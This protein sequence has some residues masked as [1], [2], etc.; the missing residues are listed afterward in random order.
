MSN[1]I[2]NI[3]HLSDLHFGVENYKNPKIPQTAR[4]RR[5]NALDGLIKYLVWLN[6]KYKLNVIVVTGDIGWAG[7]KDDY[8]EAKKWF[9]ELL[10]NLEFSPEQLCFVPGNHDLDRKKAEAK[11]IEIPTASAVADDKL[12]LENVKELVDLFAEYN[13]FCKNMM[14]VPSYTLNG[15]ESFLYG[16]REIA[17]LKFLGLNSAWYHFKD[18]IHGKLWL[19]LPQL[20]GMKAVGQLFDTDRLTMN[21]GEK[22]GVRIILCVCARDK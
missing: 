18:D 22:N 16:T 11:K 1:E 15:G 9:D 17:G 6:S 2:V 10:K 20:E 3:L 13:N 12:A 14:E 5:K 8:I 7:A 21:W 19:G 4:A